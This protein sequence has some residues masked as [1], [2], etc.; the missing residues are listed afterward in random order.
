M[1]PSPARP[2]RAWLALIVF[3][4]VFLFLFSDLEARP[5]SQMQGVS[6]WRSRPLVDRSKAAQE[7]IC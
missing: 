2:R 6:K 1:R 5:G 4:L 7:N 3:F